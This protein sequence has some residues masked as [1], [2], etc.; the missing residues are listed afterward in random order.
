MGLNSRTI[1]IVIAVACLIFYSCVGGLE[2]FLKVAAFLVISLC[3][4]WFPDAMGSYTG[5]VG[6]GHITRTTPAGI[7][8]FLGWAFLLIPFLGL[9]FF[10][11]DLCKG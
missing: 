1:S 11:L 9:V 10:V 5:W 4:I 8:F 2:G 6:R 7:V 3:C